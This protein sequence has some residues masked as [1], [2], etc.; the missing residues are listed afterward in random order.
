M[1]YS[2]NSPHVNQILSECHGIGSTGDRDG[3]VRGPAL[4]IVA[5]RYADHRSG[6]LSDFRDFGAALADDATDQL[7]GHGHFRGL[8]IGVLLGSRV[9]CTE[10][11]SGQGSES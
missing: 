1:T 4:A 11:R 9:G 8:L 6:Y 5:I 7:V 3:S 10:L 2:L